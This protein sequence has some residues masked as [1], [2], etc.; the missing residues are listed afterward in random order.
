MANSGQSLTCH[1]CG[2]HVVTADRS[3]VHKRYTCKGCRIRYEVARE[4]TSGI[5][6]GVVTVSYELQEIF[7]R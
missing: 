7:R 4:E 1:D 2:K 5:Q 6:S 3:R